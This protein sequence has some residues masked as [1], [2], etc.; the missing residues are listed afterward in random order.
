MKNA[1]KAVF[2]SAVLIIFSAILLAVPPT[3]TYT[4]SVLN[5]G[6]VLDMYVTNGN[7]RAITATADTI[8]I[9]GDFTMVG[10]RTG[11]GVPINKSDGLPVA[12]FPQVA[13][14]VVYCAIPDGEGGWYI[15]GSFTYVAGIAR[16]CLAHIYSNG[17]LDPDWNPNAD[18][19]VRALAIDGSTVYVGGV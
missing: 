18:N 14:G 6:D 11:R 10:P 5:P 17:S 7:V 13:G 15:G 12:G 3:P 4:P 2:T 9:G 8:Y 1:K 16:N 19:A